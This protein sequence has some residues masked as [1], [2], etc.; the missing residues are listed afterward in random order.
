MH[1]F[2]TPSHYKTLA[3]LKL[4]MQT[5]WTLN[6]QSSLCLCLLS[7]KIMVSA[8]MPSFNILSFETKSIWPGWSGTSYVA[9][10]GLEPHIF[11]PY[12]QTLVFQAR[13][14]T[15]YGSQMAP[16]PFSGG[17]I[18]SWVPPRDGFISTHLSFTT[19]PWV[20]S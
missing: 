12:T 13:T 17:Q 19:V 9:Q 8:P 4:A 2:E 1:A 14:T 3:E 6:S 7:A 11:M 15:T 20:A 5:R 18:H 16:V 10:V